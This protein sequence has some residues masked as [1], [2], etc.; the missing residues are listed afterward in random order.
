MA[1]V[2]IVLLSV[3]AWTGDVANLFASFPSGPVNGMSQFFGAL[4][5]SG[6]GPITLWHAVEGIL[7]VLIS[8]GIAFAA[9]A[10]TGSRNVRIVAILGLFFVLAAAL[11][12]YDFVL[13]GFLNNGNSAQMGGAFIGAYAMSFMVLYYTK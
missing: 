1:V 12:G 2:N 3:Q 8:V 4:S 11:G 7:I 10:R 13:S 5:S 6:P 9:F